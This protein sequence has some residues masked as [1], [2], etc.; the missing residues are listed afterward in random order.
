MLSFAVIVFN[1]H[2]GGLVFESIKKIN[3]L[4]LYMYSIFLDVLF[5]IQ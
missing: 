1:F 3:I 5:L 2:R 4:L